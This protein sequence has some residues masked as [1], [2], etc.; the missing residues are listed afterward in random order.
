M[1]PTFALVHGGQLGAWSFDLLREELRASGFDSIAVDLPAGDA[2]AGASR[3]ADVVVEALSA[4]EGDVILLGHSLGGLTIPV[5]AE[6][7]PV[8]RLVFLCA[9]YPEPGRS[10]FQV[11]SEEPG[12]AVAAGPSSAWQTPG[13]FH[14]LPRDLARELFF[15]DCSPAIQEWALDRMRLQSRQPFREITPLQ[16]W[17]DVPRSLIIAANDR[18]IPRASAIKTA[19]RLFDETPRE[20]EGGHCLMLSQPRALADALTTIASAVS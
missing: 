17:P 5:V 8:A 1:T 16:R 19:R 2:T 20:L 12:E 15:H 9:A 14:I 11:R 13:D 6:R 7:R 4:T 10:H 3:C 18:C